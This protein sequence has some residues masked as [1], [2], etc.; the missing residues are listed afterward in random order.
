MIVNFTFAINFNYTNGTILYRRSILRQ[1][2]SRSYGF[3]FQTDIL[4]RLTKKGYLFAEVPCRLLS[5]KSGK[6]K[7]ISFYS[8]AKIAKAYIF[9]IWDYYFMRS[10]KTSQ[11]KDFASDSV[12]RIRR[13][14]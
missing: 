7:A 5:R 2:N 1:L 10:S 9:L 13:Q 14:G 12:T 4:V 11:N 6:S 3:F 8:F